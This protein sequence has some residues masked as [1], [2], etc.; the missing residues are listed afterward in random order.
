MMLVDRV[1]FE[2]H[3]PGIPFGAKCGYRVD[4]PV[5]I[6]PE[7]CILEP[8]RFL[9]V[10]AERLPVSRIGIF[11]GI[12]LPAGISAPKNQQGENQYSAGRRSNKPSHKH[13]LV[14]NNRTGKNF[15]VRLFFQ[16]L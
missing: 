14:S 9:I 7:L 5:E 15:P 16:I 10:L 8:I 3:L 2:M 13:Q 12:A 1:T 11:C 4:P 6:D